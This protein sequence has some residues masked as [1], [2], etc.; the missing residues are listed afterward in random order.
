MDGHQLVIQ[1]D[2]VLAA[3]IHLAE[4]QAPQVSPAIKDLESLS[5]KVI[6]STG[7]S[8][9]RAS[10]IPISTQLSRQS[11]S[12]KHALMLQLH[13]EGR[14]VLFAGDGL[15]DS[16]AMAWSHVACAAPDSAAWVRDLSGLLFLHRD[17]SKLAQAITIARKTRQVVRWNI[18][19]SL[20]YNA[21]GIIAASAGLL[22]PV[23]SALIMMASSLTVII[24]SMQ[25]MDWEPAE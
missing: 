16:A 15:N 25:L 3:T 12:Q 24:Y 21:I 20:A 23:A 18:G 13:E 14:K 7:D 9:D 19:F 2:Q 10:A 11:P 4:K 5:I 8:A 6:L 1:I 22:H 17:W